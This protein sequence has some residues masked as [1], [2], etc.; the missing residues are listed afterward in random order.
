MTGKKRDELD[1]LIHTYAMHEGGSGEA[2]FK[3]S[4]LLDSLIVLD[5]SA[6]EWAAHPEAEGAIFH[7]TNATEEVCKTGNYSDEETFLVYIPRPAP[8]KL[9]DAE[10]AYQAEA[11]GLEAHDMVNRQGEPIIDCLEAY[12]LAYLAEKARLDAI[13]PSC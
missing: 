3:L 10:I 13:N 7:Y 2:F 8:A 4:A 6:E 12:R 5:I 9:T 1:K 11:K